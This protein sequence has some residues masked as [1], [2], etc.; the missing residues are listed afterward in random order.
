MVEREVRQ[1]FWAA[2]RAGM[3]TSDAAAVAGVS[4]GTGEKLVRE[5][6]GVMEPAL[7]ITRTP[8]QR[9]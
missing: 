1:R 5:F 9:R 3:W 7:G 6:G 8:S 4:R 2:I